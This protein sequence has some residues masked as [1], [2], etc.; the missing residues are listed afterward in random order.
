MFELKIAMR[1]LN[2]ALQES[3]SD[4]LQRLADYRH[5][6]YQQLKVVQ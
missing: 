1:K 3:D 2:G 5:Y 6:L 4:N